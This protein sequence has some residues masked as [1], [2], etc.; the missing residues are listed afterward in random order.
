MPKSALL[1][2]LGLA[3]GLGAA[4]PAPEPA[5]KPAEKPKL[6]YCGSAKSDKFHRGKCEWAK[7]ISPAN[8]V[9][10]ASRKEAVEKGYRP[11][12]VCKP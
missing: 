12:A 7:K 11:C 1:L 10:F 3:V 2:L 9:W 5:E 4:E 6:T 8:L